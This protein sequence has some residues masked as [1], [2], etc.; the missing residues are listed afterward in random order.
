MCVFL[1]TTSRSSD[2]YARAQGCG[3]RSPIT[4]GEAVRGGAVRDDVAG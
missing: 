1:T 2:T 4:G 3:S